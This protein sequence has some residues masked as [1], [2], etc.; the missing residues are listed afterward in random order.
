M[1]RRL[2]TAALRLTGVA[3]AFAFALVLAGLPVLTWAAP[4]EPL[5][6]EMRAIEVDERKGSSIDPKLSFV[7]HTGATV[8]LEDV[9]DGDQPVLLTLNYFRCRVVCS[10]QLNG[11]AD[12]LAELDWTAG[13]GK[14]RVVTVSID[15]NETPEDARKKRDTILAAVG[16]GDDIDWQFLTGD[17]LQIRALS[18]Q[19]GVSYAYDAEQDQYAHPA[20]AMFLSP[21]G[22]IAQYLYGLTFIPRD[23]KFALIEASE[24]KIG[25]PVEQL[26][27][28]CFAYDP[29]IGRYGPFA[30]GIV[31]IGGL[32]TVLALGSF[33]FVLWRRDR[34]RGQ[35]EASWMRMPFVAASDDGATDTTPRDGE[36]TK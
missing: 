10:V 6:P 24:G 34:R 35:V 28:S 22:K 19:L 29:T 17:A 7:D 18:E 5:S 32:L 30:F 15:P 12:A 31:R 21:D 36:V 25:S 1:S 20:V 8:A 26:Y 16:K 9:L 27:L 4:A 14:F 23:V 3:F 13:D 33:L 2:T 11:L